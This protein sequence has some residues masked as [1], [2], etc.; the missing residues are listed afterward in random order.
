MTTTTFDTLRFVEKLEK[1]GMPREQAVALAEA[2]KEAIA[3]ALETTLATKTDITGVERRLDSLDAKI[4]KLSWMLGI[5]IALAIAN[6]AKQ[7]F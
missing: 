6:F 2:Q 3:E 4:D 1:A 5:L 7:F